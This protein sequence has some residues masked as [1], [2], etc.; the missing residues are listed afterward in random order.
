MCNPLEFLKFMT[1]YHSVNLTFLVEMQFS[2][3]L[4]LED[5]VLKDHSAS[6]HLHHLMQFKEKK[7]DH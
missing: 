2:N 7:K 6:S 5:I 3:C 1:L 4:L